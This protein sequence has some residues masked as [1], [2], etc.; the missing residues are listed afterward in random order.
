MWVNKK[1][2]DISKAQLRKLKSYVEVGNG[3]IKGTNINL[4]NN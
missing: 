1:P 3:Q 4:N 2:M